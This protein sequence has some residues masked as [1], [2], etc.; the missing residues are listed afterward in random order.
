MQH[1]TH[2][3]V[4]D[5]PLQIS[6]HLAH[7]E[8]LVD[9]GMRVLNPGWRYWPSLLDVYP[10]MRLI[11]QIQVP[12]LVMHVSPLAWHLPTPPPGGNGRASIKQQNYKQ[13][14]PSVGRDCS[15]RSISSQKAPTSRASV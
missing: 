1:L 10:N 3:F 13:E 11:S 9:A 6:L 5:A 7:T 2:D 8:V 14:K 15:I 4:S 12:V